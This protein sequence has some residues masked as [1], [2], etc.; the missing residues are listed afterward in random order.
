VPNV[1]VYR[2]AKARNIP[3]LV[4]AAPEV[5]TIPNV[6]LQ[7]GAT[8]VCY[9]GGKQLRG[10]QCS[11]L[12]LGRKDLLKAAWVGSAPHHGV[13][14][15]MKVGKEEIMG[16][17]AAVEVWARQDQTKRWQGLVDKMNLI[18]KRLSSIQGVTTQVRETP[19][20]QLS[21]RSP[22]L[23][24]TWDPKALGITGQE[25]ARILDTTEPRILMGGGGG[26]GGRRGGG[27]PSGQETTGVSITA[28]NLGPN[29]EKI[30]ADR[31]HAVLTAR[32]TLP[33]P[34]PVLPPAA[35]LS[36][37]WEVAITFAAGTGIHRM[38]IRQ[39]GAAI[40]GTHRGDFLERPLSGTV[41]GETVQLR[42]SV[43]ERTIGN[44]LSYNFTGKLA[45]GAMSGGLSLGEYREATW[46]ARRRT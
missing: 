22:S 10:P 38:T 15:S 5:F 9:S 23:S 16:L 12:L 6:H 7:A 25:V 35:D 26:G 34:A 39:E 13:S 17:L 36:G 29:E 3:V 8:M 37:E 1:E 45:N 43:P 2:I 28:F 31:L 30:V 4:D 19:P 33:P 32:H 11:G 24:V 21:N 20:E 40:Q 42:S 44:A 27:A 46:T 41:N 18:A 14:R